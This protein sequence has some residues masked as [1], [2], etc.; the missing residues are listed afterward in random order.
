MLTQYVRYCGA[1]FYL[2]LLSSFGVI[3][4]QPSYIHVF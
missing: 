2:N 4:V 1:K 3:S